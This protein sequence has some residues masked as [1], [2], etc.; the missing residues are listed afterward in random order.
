MKLSLVNPAAD[1][2]PTPKTQAF[3]LKVGDHVVYVNTDAFAREQPTR[4]YAVINAV[5]P[6]IF[7]VDVV[8][9]DRLQHSFTKSQ[10]IC[11]QVKRAD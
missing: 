1:R 11:G 3:D 5:Y 6:Y 2:R 8:A 4:T 10:Y 9:G 7:T